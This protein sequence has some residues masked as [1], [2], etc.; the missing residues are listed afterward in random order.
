MVE[1]PVVAG[2]RGQV[3]GLARMRVGVVSR[4][5]NAE[6]RQIGESRVCSDL[7]EVLH[8]AVSPVERRAYETHNCFELGATNLILQPDA[9]EPVKTSTGNQRALRQ[10]GTGQ[11]TS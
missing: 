3:V 5:G 2:D 11:K 10:T 1:A 8:F 7:V 6:P 9:N 4:L